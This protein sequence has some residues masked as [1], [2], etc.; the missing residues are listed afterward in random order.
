MEQKYP[1]YFSGCQSA[2]DSFCSCGNSCVLF[3][4]EHVG[5]HFASKSETKHSYNRILIRLDQNEIETV[6]KIYSPLNKLYKNLVEGHT[7]EYTRKS[8]E[9]MEELR[10]LTFE[11]KRELE[12]AYSKYFL[13]RTTIES[14]KFYGISQLT[15]NLLEAALFKEKEQAGSLTEPRIKN[16]MKDLGYSELVDLRSEYI[17]ELEIVNPDQ[18]YDNEEYYNEEYESEEYEYEYEYKKMLIFIKTLQKETISLYAYSSDLIMNLKAQIQ[19]KEGISP[20]GQRLIFAGKQLEDD[21]TLADYNIQNESTL[22]L[23]LRLA[24]C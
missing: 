4:E 7:E 16:L 3:C 20:D 22:H 13:A 24:G 23:V 12:L 9:I 14:I 6:D 1:C 8:G 15:N 18:E 10:K 17:R 2:A 19:D 21:R 11:Y 5:V